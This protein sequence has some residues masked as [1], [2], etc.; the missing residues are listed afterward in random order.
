MHR[1]LSVLALCSIVASTMGITTFAS[2]TKLTVRLPAEPATLDWNLSTRR[3]DLLVISNL[4]EGLIEV[5]P[6]HLPRAVLAKSWMVGA[7]GKSYTFFLR[8]DAKWSDG[9]RLVAQNFID[10]WRRLI[11][12]LTA[13]GNGYF[14]LDVVGAEDYFKN[15]ETDFSKV[16]MK[17]LNDTTIQVT[18]R[19]PM[20]NW[21]WNF[22]EPATFP[23]RQDL[24][25]KHGAKFWTAPGNLVTAGPFMLE[26]HDLNSGYVLKRNPHFTGAH[27]NLTEVDFKILSDE[28]MTPAFLQGKIDLA[29]PISGADKIPLEARPFLKW[30]LAASTKRLDFNVKRPPLTSKSVRRAIALSLDRGK[31]AASTGLGMTAAT[32]GAPPSMSSHLDATNIKYDPAQA[33][34]LI[35]DAG[36]DHLNLEIL[37]P[38]FDEHAE[39]NLKIAEMIQKM[40]E[41]NLSATVTIQKAQT[42]QLYSLLRDTHDY[43]LLLRDWSASNDP[44]EFYSFY[45]TQSRKSTVWTNTDYDKLVERS[46]AEKSTPKR[47]DLYRQM[48]RLLVD[49][50]TAVLP[51]LYESDAALVNNK[52]QGFDARSPQPCVVRDFDLQP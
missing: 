11:T 46:R 33:K 30:S 22:A 34:K 18:L 45:S 36:V 27:G 28:E 42:E 50:E 43:S 20:W 4:H 3:I 19:R 2:E 5:G 23:I 37:V 49:D 40:L 44:D 8:P 16:G 29:C 15:R 51:I 47:M 24:I 13:T 12:P 35:R 14:L 32:S 25:D 17:A 38:L 10:S 26:S 9:R 48:E 31:I 1:S 39:E 41:L 21:I 6:D 52:L 7:D